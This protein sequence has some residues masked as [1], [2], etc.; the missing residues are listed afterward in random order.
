MSIGRK[1]RAHYARMKSSSGDEQLMT[2]AEREYIRRKSLMINVY[3]NG[4]RLTF[5]SYLKLVEEFPSLYSE[6]PDDIKCQELELIS[7]L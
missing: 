6:V 5:D 3:D 1:V 4:L 2:I 7:K